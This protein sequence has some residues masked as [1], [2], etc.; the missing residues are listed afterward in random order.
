MTMGIVDNCLEITIQDSGIPFEAET[1]SNLGIKKHTTH[2]DTGGNGIGYLTIFE[3]LNE[4]NASI[5]ITEH[6]PENYAFSK[7]VNVRFDGKSEYIIH[8]FRANEIEVPIERGNM[9]VF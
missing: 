2:A 8:S 5:T 9:F 4:R 3:I 1:L 6:I 7:S